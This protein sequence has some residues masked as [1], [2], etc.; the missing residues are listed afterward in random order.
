[1][2]SIALVFSTLSVAA[3]FSSNAFAQ[4]YDLSDSDPSRTTQQAIAEVQAS[5]FPGIDAKAIID[6]VA[7]EENERAKQGVG[8]SKFH[9]PRHIVIH[10][11]D[12]DDLDEHTVGEVAQALR[13]AGYD[14]DSAL[15]V[16]LSREMDEA[17]QTMAKN[18]LRKALKIALSSP[19]DQWRGGSGGGSSDSTNPSYGADNEKNYSI[20]DRIVDTVRLDGNKLRFMA[21]SDSSMDSN[22]DVSFV[23]KVGRKTYLEL[24]YNRNYLN[25]RLHYGV[26]VDAGRTDEHGNKDSGLVFYVGG[27]FD[28]NF[29]LVR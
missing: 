21:Y 27:K 10:I 6:E 5:A 24:R 15:T 25:H 17:Q 23:Q 3:V 1:M 22:R 9:E 4:S 20:A 16:Y 26:G 14:K 18:R 29:R 12:L 13:V 2:N 11:D 28:G 19:I 8:G 7:R